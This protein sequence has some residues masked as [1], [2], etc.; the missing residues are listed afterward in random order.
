MA[1][2]RPFRG[3]RYNPEKIPDLSAVVSQPH[4]RV[5]GLQDQYYNL[6]PYNV[7]RLIKG[8]E[9]P[10]DDG[11]N[12]V[13]SRA[14]ET[15]QA[16]RREGILVQDRI[17]SLY[18]LRQTFTA[19][20]GRVLTRQGL[21]AALELTRLDEGIVLPH[22]R[23]FTD[24]TL[25]RLRLLR[26]ASMNFSSV[27]MLYS[28]CSINDLIASAT[29]RPPD[30]EFREWLER[31]VKQQFWTITD[32]DVI[33][34]VVEE[35]K[36]KRNLIIADGHHRYETSLQYRD[37]MRA[38]YPH[39]SPEAGFNYRSVMLVSTDDP[40][41][42]ILPTHRLIHSY[43]KMSS[44]E[45]LERA[46]EY[47]DVTPLAGQAELEAALKAARDLSQIRFGF[48][49]GSFAA[50]TLRNPEIVD[51]LLPERTL[52]WRRLDTVVLHE[53]FIERVLGIDSQAVADHRYIEFLRDV[54]AGY[55]AVRRGQAGFLLVMNP[56]RIEQ[57]RAC[58]AAGERMPHKSTD[59]YPKVISGLVALP[60][61][62]DDLVGR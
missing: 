42:V 59:F 53:L 44:T 16:W 2:I 31:D 61:G 36:P 5:E 30:C 49:D 57:M 51:R 13:Y 27:F 6:S 7:V 62:A 14:R 38:K 33:A 58:A 46:T 10:G 19:P 26:A 24:C 50:L 60:V 23:T 11:H 1:V 52:Q 12:N 34:A 25:D 39:A 18:V 4:D 32:P 3:V 21:I 15:Y 17:P 55:E 22:E 35:M 8:M 20:D 48:Y 43:K 40:G 47:F 54:Q 28:G 29:A 56:T 41:L 37:E 9:Q 45:A